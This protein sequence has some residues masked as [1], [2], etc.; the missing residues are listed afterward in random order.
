MLDEVFGSLDDQRRANVV[1]LLRRLQDRFEQVIVITHIDGVR[2]GLD[3]VL[4]VSIDEQS[5]RAIVEQR[6]GGRLP[7]E[8]L[9]GL[10]V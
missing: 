10:E 9:M 2:D 5:G 4:E 3:R 7:D 6:D 8:T 1:E